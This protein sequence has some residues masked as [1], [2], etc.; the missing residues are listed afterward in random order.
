MADQSCPKPPF[1]PAGL[2]NIWVSTPPG[3]EYITKEELRIKFAD[4]ED[5]ECCDFLD[6]VSG[7]DK[8][9]WKYG[10]DLLRAKYM[11]QV[12]QYALQTD[13][14]QAY[15]AALKPIAELNSIEYASV[16]VSFVPSNDKSQ[17]G[18]AQQKERGNAHQG[19]ENTAISQ[20][21]YAIKANSMEFI[22][23]LE[24]LEDGGPAGDLH[25]WQDALCVWRA[26]Q[27][28]QETNTSPRFRVTAHRAGPRSFHPFTETA[29]A[30]ALARGIERRLGWEADTN[31]YEL[32]VDIK[33]WLHSVMI[34]IKL[35]NARMSET[36]GLLLRQPAH[37]ETALRWATRLIPRI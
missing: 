25:A 35:N 24:Q 10:T 37:T 2:V 11:F 1:D 19:N 8:K 17:K 5:Y 6:V 18:N 4:I 36:N 31:N 9:K 29:M 30:Q 13:Q 14:L 12:R 28:R 27:G 23:S 22:E 26:W 7:L 20:A 21:R 32:E 34:S 33:L 15:T 16:I 3:F